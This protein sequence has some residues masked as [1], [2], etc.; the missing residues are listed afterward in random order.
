LL[1]NQFTFKNVTTKLAQ[2]T[3]K[4]KDILNKLYIKVA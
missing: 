3:S 1:T 2:E 4:I